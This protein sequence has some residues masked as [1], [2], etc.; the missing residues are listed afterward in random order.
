M[1]IRLARLLAKR[2]ATP[3]ILAGT[4]ALA[5]LGAAALNDASSGHGQQN[6]NLI[7]GT[8]IQ[9]MV[10]NGY[11]I[12]DPDGDGHLKCWINASQLPAFANADC[13]PDGDYH[14][15]CYIDQY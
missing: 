7:V 2:M 5:G 14:F 13:H 10:Q 12:P 8:P 6:P 9:Q 3:V 4:L 1:Q 15:V 11:C